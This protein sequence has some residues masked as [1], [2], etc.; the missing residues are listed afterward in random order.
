MKTPKLAEALTAFQKEM[1]EVKLDSTVKVKT[2][3]GA[4]YDFKYATLQNI[5]KKALPVLT[6]HGLSVTQVFAGKYLKTILLHTSGE[7][8]VSIVPIDLT[9]GTMQ[10]VGSRISYMKRY[11]MSA[12][13]GIVAEE[14][15]DANIA[16][17]NQYQKKAK[18]A[19]AKPKP[20]HPPVSE[21]KDEPPKEEPKEK[22]KYKQYLD[23]MAE[24]KKE[25][26]LLTGST[27]AYYEAL[28]AYDVE[29]ANE[30]KNVAK[31]RELWKDLQ[32]YIV[33][34]K[35]QEIPLP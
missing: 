21:K 33:S 17:G 29:H 31:G 23:A 25:I 32:K 8:Q 30:I 11:S 12:I 27:D 28:K 5:M 16:D 19:S 10:E 26:E 34:L 3:S 9:T 18:P 6:K 7:K 22:S 24:I 13:L 15:D 14:D 35:N 20:T 2:R 4:S 1:P